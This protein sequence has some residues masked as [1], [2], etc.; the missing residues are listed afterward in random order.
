MST[1]NDD[2]SADMRDPAFAAEFERTTD[3]VRRERYA[4]EFERLLIEGCD[5]AE[6]FADAAMVVTDEV[7]RKGCPFEHDM[8][9]CTPECV[10]SERRERYAAAI[11]AADDMRKDWCYAEA[12]A[13]MALADEEIQATKMEAT[14]IGTRRWSEESVRTNRLIQ[15]L[16]S[17]LQES[18]DALDESAQ[19]LDDALDENT[20]LREKAQFFAD[21]WERATRADFEKAQENERL[22]AELE[23]VKKAAKIITENRWYER[24]GRAED[25]IS[26]VRDVLPSKSDR[27]ELGLPNDLAYNAGEHDMAD[28]VREI[29]NGEQ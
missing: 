8:D 15:D 14:Q 17:D 28:A 7:R 22:R 12:D 2:L 16:R 20:R 6:G 18:A 27:Q 26:R 29:L 23:R 21:A 25:T 1:F 11:A 10:P 9:D 3:E 19:L 13:A 24:L 5:T 4:A